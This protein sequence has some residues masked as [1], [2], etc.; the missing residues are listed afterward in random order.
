MAI[1]DATGTVVAG[2]F[3]GTDRVGATDRGNG[4]TGIYVEEASNNQLGPGN[5]IAWN[6]S[7][8]TGI[9][10]Q[11]GSGTASSRT[12]STTTGAWASRL[13][14]GANGDLAAPELDRATSSGGPTTVTVTIGG[15]GVPDGS[16]FVEFFENAACDTSPDGAASAR[17][18]DVS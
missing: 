13:S 12:R 9:E 5:T 3:V 1:F 16:Y 11:S 18:E 2:N 8:D 17:A 10:I 14:E 7:I 6:G 15:M 4:S